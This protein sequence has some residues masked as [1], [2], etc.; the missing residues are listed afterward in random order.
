MN[1]SER[2]KPFEKAIPITMYVKFKFKINRDP[3][4]NIDDTL[5]IFFNQRENTNKYSLINYAT[6]N[7]EKKHLTEIVKNHI[8]GPENNLI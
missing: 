4:F 3:M 2:V 7:M 8:Y 1:I 5:Y 6:E